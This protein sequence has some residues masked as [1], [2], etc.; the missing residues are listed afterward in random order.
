MKTKLLIVSAAAALISLSAHAK[1]AGPDSA[2]FTA[3]EQGDVATLQQYFATNLNA[4]ALLNDLFRDAVLHGQKDTTEFLLERGADVNKKGFFDLTPL[5]HLAMYGIRDDA[6]SAAVAKVLITHGAEVN[7]I[8][9]YHGTPLL[10]AVESKKSQ[11]VRVLLEHGANIVDRYTGA[12]S[13]MTPLHMAVVDKDKDMVAVLLEFKAPIDAVD[14]D[15]ATPLAMAESRDQTEIVAMLRAANPKAAESGPSYSPLPDKEEIR[16]LAQRIANG[17]D[18]AYD[19]LIALTSKLYKEIKDY[20]A[21]RARVIAFA[22]RVR[23]AADLL[24]QEAAKGNEHALAALKKSLRPRTALTSFAPDALATAAV[25]GNQEALDILIHYRDWDIG[26]WDARFAI[27]KSVQANVAPAVEETAKWLLTLRDD[28]RDGGLVMDTTNALA[29]AAAKGNQT[30]KD[31]LEKFFATA[32][33][34]VETQTQNFQRPARDPHVPAHWAY[35]VGDPALLD[36]V[37]A[38]T[39]LLEARDENGETALTAMVK[40]HNAQLARVLLEHGAKIPPPILP[41]SGY[42]GMGQEFKQINLERNPMLWAVTHG[43]KEMVALLLEFKAPLNAV[44]QDGRTPLHYAVE[45]KKPEIVQLLLAAKA[46]VDAV[47]KDGATPLLLAETAENKEITAMLLQAGAASG[48]PIPSRQEMHAL[49]KRICAGDADS[50]DE[51][52]KVAEGLYRGMDGK[53]PQAQKMLVWSRMS[54]AFDLLGDEAAKGNDNA[55]EA[56]KK[57]LT[58]KSALKGEA[59]HALGKA[60]A[61]GNAEALDILINYQQWGIERLSAYFALQAAGDANQESAVNVFIAMASDPVAAKKQYYG[62]GWLV[63]EVLQNAASQGNQKAQ[64]ALDRFIAASQQ[65]KN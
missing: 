8:D 26:E 56:L 30:A 61:A 4:A 2:F 7:P 24:G 48:A 6:K 43:D 21:E 58:Q 11:M 13:G 37:L 64:E 28:A 35:L 25:A 42:R 52:S 38:S 32:P 3:A 53:T 23:A 10:H 46:P 19:E 27:A 41:P 36:R 17:D 34:R 50:F 9:Q 59:P 16:A 65:A 63:K 49:A 57:C 44:D 51:L 14:R 29:S 45:Y 62:V 39:N 55:L 31:A 40:A 60:A 12:N 1:G 20:Q 33:P 15:G 47:A 54:A 5:G 22:G 18:A